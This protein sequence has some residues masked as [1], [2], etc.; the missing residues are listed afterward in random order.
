MLTLRRGVAF[1][2]RRLPRESKFP[3]YLE[4]HVAVFFSLTLRDGFFYLE[5]LT[6]REGFISTSRA[7]PGERVH[8][9]LEGPTLRGLQPELGGLAL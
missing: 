6:L 7:L 3:F 8:V 1:T 5:G 4:S 9:Y 2:L